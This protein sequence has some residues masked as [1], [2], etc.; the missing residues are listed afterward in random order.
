[1]VAV[2]LAA[3]VELRVEDQALSLLNRLAVVEVLAVV[4]ERHLAVGREAVEEHRSVVGHAAVAV[5]EVVRV[6]VLAVL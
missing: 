1:M 6:A 2:P 4:E 5:E 3:P